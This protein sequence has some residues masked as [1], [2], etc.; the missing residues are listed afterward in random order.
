[1]KLF[2]IGNGFDLS[3]G[4]AT[5]YLDFLDYLNNNDGN[6]LVYNLETIAGVRK[7]LLWSNFEENLGEISPNSYTERAL[8][9]RQEMYDGL[10]YPYDAED[11]INDYVD[12]EALSDLEFLEELTS[13][14]I[15]SVDIN[16]SIS[17]VAK[18]NGKIYSEIIDNESFYINFNYTMVLEEVYNIEEEN[19]FH[20]HGDIEE[21]IIGHDSIIKDKIINEEDMYSDDVIFEKRIYDRIKEF[22]NNSNKNISQNTEKLYQELECIDHV[23]EIDEIVVIGLSFG[24]ID[25]PYFEFIQQRFRNAVWKFS[26]FGI[27]EH[28]KQKDKD[29]KVS[30]LKEIGIE[31][32]KIVAQDFI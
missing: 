1:M 16:N 19:I 14:W 15:R 11:T 6:G 23:T 13:Q 2:V 28:K 22:V 31:E 27:D 4:L 3:H 5:S 20:I 29:K 7:D 9:S 12:Q 8:Q 26:Y 21:P 18:E 25:K 32:E 10:E 30:F 24:K 17:E